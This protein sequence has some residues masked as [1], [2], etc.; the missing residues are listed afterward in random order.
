MRVCQFRHFGTGNSR[1][2][3]VRVRILSRG[4]VFLDEKTA[5]RLYEETRTTG[6]SAFGPAGCWTAAVVSLAKGP[7][8]VKQWGLE[9]PGWGDIL[10]DLIHTQ[11]HE[12]EGRRDDGDKRGDALAGG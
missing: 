4:A 3:D 5:F 11:A 7:R 12:E 10:V 6:K 1:F 2:P 8:N 9:R